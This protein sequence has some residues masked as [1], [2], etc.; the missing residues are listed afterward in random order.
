MNLQHKR[1]FLPQ[2]FHFCLLAIL[3]F[4]F[5]LYIFL[6]HSS[7]VMGNKIPRLQAGARFSHCMKREREGEGKSEREKKA[8]DGQRKGEN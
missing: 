8:S 1:P 4:L 5:Q 3:A 7:A 6:A 2:I